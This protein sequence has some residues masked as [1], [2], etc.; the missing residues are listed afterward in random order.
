MQAEEARRTAQ[1]KG[2]ALELRVARLFEQRGYDVAHNTW[3]R[4]RSGAQHQVDV[5]ARHAAPLHNSTL[6]IEAKAYAGAVDKDR[7]LKLL[8]IVDDVGAD[9]GII[10]TTGRAT[11]DALRT[12][13][14]RAIDIWDRERLARLLGETEV[15]A[16]EQAAPVRGTG[17]ERAVAPR[18]DVEALHTELRRTAAKRRRGTL[19]IGRV[20]EDLADCR[21]ILYP[22][23]EA[24]LEVHIADTQRVGMFRKQAVTRLSLT[25]VSIDAVTGAVVT[26]DA[27]HGIGYEH[28][29]LADLGHDERQLL[30]AVR[31]HSFTLSSV[32][33][34]GLSETRVRKAIASLR[35]SGLLEAGHAKPVMYRATRSFP[36][37]PRALASLSEALELNEQATD[38]ERLRCETKEPGAVIAAVEDYWPGVR[39]VGMAA[40]LYPFVVARYAHDDGSVRFEAYDALTGQRSEHVADVIRRLAGYAPGARPLPDA[41][42]ISSA[43]SSSSSSSE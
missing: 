18:I 20:A 21:L 7:I 27:A 41:D 12:A 6:I 16:V 11:P 36:P 40:L 39:V 26:V 9:R 14:G 23:Y 10:V 31:G 3:M 35:A 38:G 4:G 32:A 25:H 43:S 17:A 24:E 33:V 34:A 30:K 1:Q 37:D 2:L 13:A 15:G 5:L 29:W 8:H 28:A 42:S 19:G 22:F